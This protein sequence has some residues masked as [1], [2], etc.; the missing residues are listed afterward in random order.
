MDFQSRGTSVMVWG[1]RICSDMRL[2]MC[3]ET[4]LIGDRYIS[5]L[6]IH[7]YPFISLCIRIW[8]IIVEQRDT[9]TSKVVTEQQEP[10]KVSPKSPLNDHYYFFATCYSEEISISMHFYGFVCSIKIMVVLPEYF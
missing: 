1:M 2:L 10:Q 6:S 9:S 5:T 4:I 3:L 7:I 8:I